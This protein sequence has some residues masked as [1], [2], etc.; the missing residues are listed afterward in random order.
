M[1]KYVDFDG[2]IMDTF[3]PIFGD[4]K[5]KTMADG[6][7][8]SDK[9]HV[10]T[11]DWNLALKNSLIINDAIEIIKLVDDISILTRIY[12]MENEG[13]AKVKFLRELG[14]KCDIILAPYDLKK[15]EVVNAR[16]NILIDDSLFNLEDWEKAS[17][18]PIFFNKDG[19]DVDGW[20]ETN[21]K[22]IKTRT[23]E[24]LKKY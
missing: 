18:I 1:K 21:K 14:V 6:T 23:L 13:V 22:F 15:T 12:S 11:V 10:Q 17:G 4:Y 5:K 7:F 8:I 3:L 24:I 9:E 2:V 16:G 19:L 20:G